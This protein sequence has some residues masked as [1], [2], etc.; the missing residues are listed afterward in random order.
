ME[1]ITAPPVPDLAV[2]QNVGA[3]Q[4]RDERAIRRGGREHS[5]E[6]AWPTEV[7][8]DEVDLFLVDDLGGEAL[9]RHRAVELTRVPHVRDR[10]RRPPLERESGGLRAVPQRARRGQRSELDRT[11]LVSPFALVE[12]TKASTPAAASA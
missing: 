1:W 12:S 8:V 9:N 7:A 11:D 5:A 6:A 4:A 3:T 10:D 2:E